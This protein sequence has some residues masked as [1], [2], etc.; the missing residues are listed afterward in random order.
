MQGMGCKIQKDLCLFYESHNT[1]TL[2]LCQ[3]QGEREPLDCHY[4]LTFYVKGGNPISHIQTKEKQA[5]RLIL[6][7]LKKIEWE[8]G[9]V[10]IFPS[11]CFK[12]V[13]QPKHVSLQM[14]RSSVCPRNVLHL[15]T[16]GIKKI[17]RRSRTV[18]TPS[19]L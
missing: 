13:T 5:Q 9:G 7:F 18:M 6:A 8:K 2:R 1:T 3:W 10:P 12:H 14:R 16:Q 11:R 4:L 17:G 19:I 15:Y